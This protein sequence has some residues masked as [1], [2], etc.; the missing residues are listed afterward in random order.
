MQE[1]KMF[2]SIGNEVLG[3]E[4]QKAETKVQRKYKVKGTQGNS[5]STLD[6]Q[7]ERDNKGKCM[8]G[9]EHT[10]KDSC[11]HAQHYDRTAVKEQ[12]NIIRN[13]D[14]HTNHDTTQSDELDMKRKGKY[15]QIEFRSEEVKER[16]TYPD[17]EKYNLAEEKENVLKKNIKYK[18]STSPKL[19]TSHK[20]NS[21]KN[22]KKVQVQHLERTE[23]VEAKMKTVINKPRTETHCEQQA[24]A[25]KNYIVM[26]E[27]SERTSRN[28]LKLV[29]DSN[30]ENKK[31]EEKNIM[32]A[33]QRNKEVNYRK[34]KNVDRIQVPGPLRKDSIQEMNTLQEVM[35]PQQTST[36]TEPCTE[37]CRIKQTED[38]PCSVETYGDHQFHCTNKKGRRV[39]SKAGPCTTNK[40]KYKADE[41]VDRHVRII[42]QDQMI[43]VRPEINNS[44]S[45]IGFGEEHI[46][47]YPEE[48]GE[49]TTKLRV[50]STDRRLQIR[51]GENIQSKYNVI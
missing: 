35:H 2:C 27:V 21:G 4:K 11:E 36:T 51:K 17:V 14:E 48:V 39:D 46:S 3:F 43:N 23:R 38:A 50:I 29:H 41:S 44:S 40:E 26:D 42:K 24:K 19:R 22:N 5:T 30:I 33:A 49:K 1:N 13:I 9:G 10:H 25:N 45:A 47:K 16:E 37:A 18:K 20:T 12:D 6:P 28:A 31:C 32:I 15:Q 34:L 8:E 7:R